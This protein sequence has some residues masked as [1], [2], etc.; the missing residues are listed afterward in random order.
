M[1]VG[2][3]CFADSSGWPIR[4]TPSSLIEGMSSSV[5]GPVCRRLK[6]RRRRRLWMNSGGPLS[7]WPTA[8]GGGFLAGSI[9]ISSDLWWMCWLFNDHSKVSV[10]AA[11]RKIRAPP[12]KFIDEWPVGTTR[13]WAV[14]PAGLAR[15]PLTTTRA[16][17]K[18][19]A[20][21]AV[22]FIPLAGAGRASQS[23][24]PWASMPLIIIWIFRRSPSSSAGY[25]FLVKQVVAASS[26]NILSLRLLLLL[27]LFLLL[28]LLLSDSSYY[29]FCSSLF[30]LHSH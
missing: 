5:C 2:T 21:R 19:N 30:I 22:F 18:S 25:L 17:K 14:R 9:W 28:L 1:F 6:S 4:C 7:R 27:L 13:S 24:W 20:K 8:G 29:Y 16:G 11:A 15:E 26:L 23:A 3:L 12:L 10:A